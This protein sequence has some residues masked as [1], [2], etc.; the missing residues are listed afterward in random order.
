MTSPVDVAYLDTVDISSL[1]RRETGKLDD[2]KRLALWSE[3]MMSIPVL[4][5]DAPW[6]T[7]SDMRR[8]FRAMPSH[9]QVMARSQ[10]QVHHSRRDPCSRAP[11]CL[12][13][14]RCRRACRCDEEDRAVTLT[15]ELIALRW[16]V[17][18][19]IDRVMQCDPDGP[20]DEAITLLNAV[21]RQ[22]I[23]VRTR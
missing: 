9:R 7:K 10:R 8:Y 15:D 18:E 2:R 20:R 22:S 6:K 16:E 12:S 11:R 19:L 4:G 1:A 13:M 3:L 5:A 21:Y 23:M 14:V 17:D